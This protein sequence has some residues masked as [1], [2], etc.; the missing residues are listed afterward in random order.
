MAVMLRRTHVVPTHLHTPETAFSIGSVGISVRQFLVLLIGSAISYDLWLHLVA[1]AGLPGG[2]IV[3]L[4][5]ALVPVS[6]TLAIAF[7]KIAGRPL[8][9]WLLVLLRFWGRP[10]RLVWRSVYFQEWSDGTII[11]EGEKGDNAYA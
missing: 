11:S 9:T 8:E 4:L 3:R 10:R 1:L 6:L 2:Q 5:T 7:L